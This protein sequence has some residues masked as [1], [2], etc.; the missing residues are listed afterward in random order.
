MGDAS[1]LGVLRASDGHEVLRE[2]NKLVEMAHDNLTSS[3]CQ[4]NIS[5]SRKKVVFKD[6]A[7]QTM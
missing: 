1:E 7:R 6:G 5:S 2:T 3:K 4:I